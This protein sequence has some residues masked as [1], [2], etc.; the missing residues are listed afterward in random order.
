[1][2]WWALSGKSEARGRNG[3]YPAGA[4][5]PQMRGEEANRLLPCVTGRL[6]TVGVTRVI[7]KGVAASRIDVNLEILS[8]L[9]KALLKLL[10]MRDRNYFVVLS[11]KSE[12]GAVQA[13]SQLD[14]CGTRCSRGAS[15]RRRR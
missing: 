11:V 6:G 14:G 12:Q 5:R 15:R 9:F 4:L 7:E 13:G 2:R 1:M 8:F 10:N 3:A